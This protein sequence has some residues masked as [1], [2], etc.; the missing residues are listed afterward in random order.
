MERR[1]L[2]EAT[3]GVNVYKQFRR[4]PYRLLIVERVVFEKV[5][6][7][8]GAAMSDSIM[9]WRVAL[10]AA[11]VESVAARH[12]HVKNLLALGQVR[13]II[14]NLVLQS[15]LLLMILLHLAR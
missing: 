15:L 1:V 9:E 4:V 3:F 12:E 2:T 8:V 5:A 13:H 14:I 7:E 10:V 6:D 11:E